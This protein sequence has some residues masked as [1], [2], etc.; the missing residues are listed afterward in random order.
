MWRITVRI[1]DVIAAWL[2]LTYACDMSS[3]LLKVV[4]VE[5]GVEC[6]RVTHSHRQLLRLFTTTITCLSLDQGLI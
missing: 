5:Q 2:L 4:G 1:Y 6:P 3:V